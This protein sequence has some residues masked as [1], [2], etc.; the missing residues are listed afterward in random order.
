MHTRYAWVLSGRHTPDPPGQE[1]GPRTEFGAFIERFGGTTISASSLDEPLPALARV[2]K[3]AGRPRLALASF[4]ASRTGEFDAIIASGEDIGIPIALASAAARS[5]PPVHTMFHGHHLDSAKLRLLAPVLRR[6]PHLHFHCLS[7]SLRNLTQSVLGIPDA[8]C[9][10]TG[11]AADTDY[12]A[13]DSIADPAVIAS[14]GAANRD[15]ATLADAV[16]GLPVSVRIAA[17]STWMPPG[18]TTG[19]VEWPDNAEARSYGSY[20]RLRDL[21]GRA[22]FVVIPLHAARY[23]CGYAVIAEAMAMGRTVVVTRTDAPADFIIP[24][25]TGVFVEPGD[26]AGLRKTIAQLLENPAETVAMG[27]RARAMM[28]GGHGLEQY[29]ERLAQIVS[30]SITK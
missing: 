13:D 12:F 26:V 30:A 2:L 9:H 7:A 15:Y 11:Y 19:P 6:L 29:C 20:A 17:A 5:P 4:V 1:A 24:G 27:Q 16:R 3:R 28:V 18:A 8:R 21:Y 22:L 25:V 14:A 23:A 10:A